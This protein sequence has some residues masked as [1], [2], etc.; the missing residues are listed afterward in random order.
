MPVACEQVAYINVNIN[1][2]FWRVKQQ[3]NYYT[4]KFIHFLIRQSV[5]T[6]NF[7]SS[8]LVLTGLWNVQQYD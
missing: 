7:Y 5:V 3:Y 8:K 2:R 1:I 6:S 4:Y